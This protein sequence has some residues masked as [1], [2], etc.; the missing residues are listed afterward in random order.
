M[1]TNRQPSPRTASLRALAREL[2][3]THS[4]LSAAAHDGRLVD[5]VRIDARGHV[6]VVDADAAARNWRGVSGRMAINMRSQPRQRDD[7]Q[8]TL[9]DRVL[10]RFV[11]SDKLFA[12]RDALDVLVAALAASALGSKRAT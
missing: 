12:E 10:D 2:G 8:I 4:S 11:T 9:Y 7:A 6:V 3:V 5:G 1:T